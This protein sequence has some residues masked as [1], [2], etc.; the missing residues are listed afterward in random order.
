MTE[1]HR[2]ILVDAARAAALIGLVATPAEQCSS[3]LYNYSCLVG[4]YA[5]Y[6]L[7]NGCQVMIGTDTQGL[8][9]MGARVLRP[10]DGSPTFYVM[11]V[12]HT[13]GEGDPPSG[14]GYLAI[15]DD[16][17]HTEFDVESHFKDQE[18]CF[19]EVLDNL[20]DW[21]DDIQTLKRVQFK[22]PILS[23]V[24]I[25]DEGPEGETLEA[26][27]QRHGKHPETDPMPPPSNILL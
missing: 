26:A 27:F 12:I 9:L 6:D 8:P 1:S 10:S 22:P 7:P 3:V 14:Y 5:A 24:N 17:A 21:A 20:R 25:H 13:D 15:G 2:A 18:S 19:T 4:E 16:G 23:S 11:V